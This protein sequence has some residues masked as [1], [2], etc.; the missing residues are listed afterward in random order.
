MRRASGS[1]PVFLAA[2][3]S[4]PHGSASSAQTVSRRLIIFFTRRCRLTRGPLAQSG[5]SSLLRST[6][7]AAARAPAS[8]PSSQCTTTH[9]SVLP[10]AGPDRSSSSRT[11]GSTTSSSTL[12]VVPSSLCVPSAP[13]LIRCEETDLRPARC[14]ATPPRCSPSTCAPKGASPPQTSSL[15]SF[16]RRGRHRRGRCSLDESRESSGRVRE[17]RLTFPAPPTA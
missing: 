9:S 12:S 2:G 13:T 5:S 14:R 3:S 15:L 6:P 8:P 10:A 7:R 1:F 4:W 16:L 11:D 17:H